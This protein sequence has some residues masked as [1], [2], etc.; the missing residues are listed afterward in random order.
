MKASRIVALVFGCIIALIGA[1][2]LFGAAALTWAYATQRD[3]D[4]YFTSRTVR[5][6]TVTPAVH[7]DNI[8]FGSD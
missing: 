4:G 1:A 6:E 2:L 3:D 7:S 8:D 5:I